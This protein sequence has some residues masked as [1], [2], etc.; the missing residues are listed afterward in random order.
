MRETIVTG[1]SLEGPV[2][3][4]IEDENALEVLLPVTLRLVPVLLDRTVSAGVDIVG[5][6]TQ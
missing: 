6:C 4:A 3:V 2:A 1:G 5:R